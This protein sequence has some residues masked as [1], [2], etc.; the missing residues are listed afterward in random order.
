MKTTIYIIMA[1]LTLSTAT[2]QLYNFQEMDTYLGVYN[3][4]CEVKGIV[5]DLGVRNNL[6]VWHIWGNYASIECEQPTTAYYF[7]EFNGK[8]GF[9][10]L[11]IK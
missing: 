10:R 6:Q 4:T 1:L 5:E 7:Y 2:A 9:D 8:Y 11:F 3:S